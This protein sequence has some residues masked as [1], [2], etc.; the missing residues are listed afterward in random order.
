MDERGWPREMARDLSILG[1]SPKVLKG[2]SENIINVRFKQS[3]VKFFE[4]R[5]VLPQD[6]VTSRTARYHPLNWNDDA[7]EEPKLAIRERGVENRKRKSE[8]ERNRAAIEGTTYSPR[9]DKLQNALD[10]YLR[11]VHGQNSVL[12]EREF[13]D[14]QLHRGK[15][16]IYFE[17]KIALTAKS[18]IREALGQLL[19]YNMYPGQQRASEMVI[20][21][22]GAATPDDTAYLKYL[23][24]EFG[25]KARYIRWNW[26]R[27]A[28]DEIL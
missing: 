15:E 2:S 12:Y 9:P 24:R 28:L 14:I 16:V 1:L 18:C 6:H 10:K 13:V 19:E 26:E 5:F 23:R 25:I 20:V 8:T 3:N 4:P 7:P 27:N 11:R 22:E 21:G 17:I